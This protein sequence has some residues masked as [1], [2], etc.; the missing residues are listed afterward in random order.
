M[1]SELASQ[2]RMS[3]HWQ[4]LFQSKQV[5]I[6]IC[7]CNY[8]SLTSGSF[9]IYLGKLCFQSDCHGL[10]SCKACIMTIQL[11]YWRAC[12]HLLFSLF[13]CVCFLLPRSG[14]PEGRARY[15]FLSRALYCLFSSAALIGLVLG[16]SLCALWQVLRVHWCAVIPSLLWNSRMVCLCMLWKEDAWGWCMFLISH[17]PS[18]CFC[19]SAPFFHPGLVS[20]T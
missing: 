5:N 15:S 20:I 3:S 10:P 14:S 1:H 19:V 4:W 2:T 18:S 12:F 6:C 8:L 17:S 9:P 7:F 16:H 13:L 11:Q